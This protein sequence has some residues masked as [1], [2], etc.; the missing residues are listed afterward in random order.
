MTKAKAKPTRARQPKGKSRRVPRR[1]PTLAEC[2]KAIG[3]KAEQWVARCYEIS[4]A[5]VAA[6]LVDGEAVY[7]HWIGDIASGSHFANRGQR[8]PFVQHGWILLKDGRVLDPTRWVF[9]DVAPYLYVGV[10]PDHWSVT[11]CANCG[12][13]KEE[14]RDDGHKDQCEMFEVE[15]W[16]Y[17][18]GGNAWREAMTRGRPAPVA[19]GPR[20]KSGL[21]GFTAVWVA[22]LLGDDD[23]ST[24]ATNQIFYLANLSYQTI[25]HAVGPDGVKMIYE[26]IADL[27][28]TSICFIPVDNANRAKRECGFD[29]V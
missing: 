13:L 19:E 28:E 24:L 10:E 22:A 12:L 27:D 7:G 9:E 18:E 6:S 4:C 20:K 29:R 2:E 15:K 16:P 17:D 8:L 3:S 5:I 11:P 21:S 1:L 25:K 26:A 23:V 14:H